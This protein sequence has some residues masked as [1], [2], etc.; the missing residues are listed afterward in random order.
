MH[1]HKLHSQID[2]RNTQYVTLTPASYCE[3]TLLVESESDRKVVFVSDSVRSSVD[4]TITRAATSTV[5]ICS[6][7]RMLYRLSTRI[8]I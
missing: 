5:F 1:K 8:L 3:W 7:T 4:I 6:S 2:A